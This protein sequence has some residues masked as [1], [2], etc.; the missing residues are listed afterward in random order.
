[1]GLL[2]KADAEFR[3]PFV[4]AYNGQFTPRA[5]DKPKRRQRT[6][7]PRKFELT[8]ICIPTGAGSSRLIMILYT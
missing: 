5:D 6:S 8:A 7:K 2:R 4:M 3:A 1:M